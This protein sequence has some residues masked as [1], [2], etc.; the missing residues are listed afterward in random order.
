MTLL[1][2]LSLFACNKDTVDETGDSRVDADNDSYFD[3]ED[4]D[5]NN[6]AV[7]P[8]AAEY[9]DGVDN[10]CDGAVDEEP[11]DG[12]DFYLDADGDGYGDD[13]E[14]LNACEAPEGAVE[15]GGDCDDGD[16]AYYPG[17]PE[18]NC[19][20][21][22]DYNCDGSVGYADND[23]DGWAA[24]QEC[25]DSV[26]EVFP[27]APEYC[28]EIDNN[29]DG[30]ID[31]DGAL[32]ASTWYLDADA[33][34]YGSDNA[35]F[36]R[37]AC[38]QPEGYA[39][40]NQDCDD[41][42]AEINPE[43]FWYADDD[44]DGYGDPDDAQQVCEQ[45]SGTTQDNQDCD[46]TDADLNPD[47][48]WFE[49]GDGDGYGATTNITFSCEQPSGY[50][51]NATDCDD[52]DSTANPGGTETCDLVDNDCN[53]VVDDDYA[54]D[55]GDWYA[56]D[57]GDGFG[58]ASDSTASCTQPLGYVAD[59][60]DCD[61]TADAV[62]PDAIEICNDGIDNDCSTGLDF[63]NLSLDDADA[64]F[65]G[66]SGADELGSD[67]TAVPDLDGDGNDE[68]LIAAHHESSVQEQNG[69]AYLFYGSV[70][71]SISSASADASFFGANEKDRAGSGVLGTVDVTGDGVEDLLVAA[72]R[73]PGSGLARGEIYVLDGATAWSGS[74]DL[75]SAATFTLEG[76]TNYDRVGSNLVFAGDTDGDGQAE[77]MSGSLYNDE[78]GADGGAV[79]VFGGVS[80]SG[81][82]E[83]LYD[84][85]IYG[86]VA[87][88]NLGGNLAAGDLDGDGQDDL[89]VGYTEASSSAGSVGVFYG[90]INGS[91]PFS[92]YD[93][94][95]TGDTASDEVGAAVAVMP[96][97]DGDGYAELVIGAPGEDSGGSAAG[98]VFV[99]MGPVSSGS[100]SGADATYTGEG[101]GDRAGAQLATGGDFD[102]DG[103]PDLLI[104][105]ANYGS[106]DQGAAYLVYG[107]SSV[108]GTISLSDADGRF[109]GAAS[110]DAAG[111]SVG[112]AGDTDGDGADELLIG[113]T[114][115]DLGGSSSGAAYLVLSVD[116]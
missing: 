21:P 103:D 64:I 81:S 96:D 6:A 2:A 26:A 4:C 13:S 39:D 67:L 79:Y 108:S 59:D 62:N 52:T 43:T 40:N 66:A 116:E 56:D 55:A 69:A 24:C 10:N 22:N 31:E 44:G 20:D 91:V 77:F 27:G 54:T 15:V 11:V 48:L 37:Q 78:G 34:T 70:S 95:L 30:D 74:Y 16:T 8:G 12:V 114:G 75:G 102:G 47:T 68:L 94:L 36:A 112:F 38:E 65:Y 104:G 28:D 51:D 7:Y 99:L 73:A 63:C 18:D 111:A 107:N 45:P 85:K 105:A 23:G 29:C 109:E 106:A 90:G 5:D 60:T 49:D 1:L 93:A 32:D 110:D 115:A 86:D 41:L 84:L 9:C 33:D 35:S 82:V 72:L 17:A 80:A 50:A 19:A 98:A 83:D 71:G 25:D 97:L 3:D 61:D 88:A 58:D 113:A 100:V 87:G 101:G 53:G 46:D 42:D 89:V 57:D 14:I 92:D 76:D